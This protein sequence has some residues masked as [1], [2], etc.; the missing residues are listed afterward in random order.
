MQAGPLAVLAQVL[1]LDG[2]PTLAVAMRASAHTLGAHTGLRQVVPG[3]PHAARSQ[4][5]AEMW[6]DP[7]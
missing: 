5:H 7:L 3:Y 6:V 1:M 2:A 4:P